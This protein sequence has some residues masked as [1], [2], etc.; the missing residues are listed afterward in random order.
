MDELRKGRTSPPP[1][2]HPLLRNHLPVPI[3]QLTGQIDFIDPVLGLEHKKGP[4]HLGHVDGGALAE[5]GG[6][7]VD[8][9][10]AEVI[11]AHVKQLDAVAAEGDLG[12]PAGD[13]VPLGIAD[14][15]LGDEGFGELDGHQHLF[16]QLHGI[17]GAGRAHLEEAGGGQVAQPVEAVVEAVRFSDRERG[18]GLPGEDDVVVGL[19]LGGQLDEVEPALGESRD[20]LD[21]HAGAVVVGGLD[22]EV[23]GIGSIALEQGPGARILKGKDAVADLVSGDLEGA[24]LPAAVGG[25]DQQA[26]AVVDLGPEVVG[27]RM[28]AL[29]VPEHGGEGGDAELLDGA[30]Q[31]Q[32]GLDVHRGDL[33]G[34]DGEAVGPGDALALEQGLGDEVF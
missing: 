29:A 7:V 11:Q 18:L 10:H 20:R 2:I 30:A 9:G 5:A 19:V 3:L 6:E 23:G 34:G 26:V 32:L 27:F 16:G 22:V 28:G 4:E 24:V 17:A 31:G 8:V 14:L 15:R 13:V 12:L 25:L 21:L 33:A 1:Q